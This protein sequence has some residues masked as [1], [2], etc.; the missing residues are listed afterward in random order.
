MRLH[1]AGA[2]LRPRHAQELQ[3]GQRLQRGRQVSGPPAGGLLKVEPLSKVRTLVRWT[4]SDS[5]CL[6]HVLRQV[7]SQIWSDIL[8]GAAEQNPAVLCRFLLLSFA[9]LKKY[10]Y[11]SW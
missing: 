3:H 6:V 9:D 7:A 10:T 5:P 1:F 2:M 8:S 11:L 4:R